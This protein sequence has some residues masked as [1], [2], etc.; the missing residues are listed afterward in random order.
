M[1]AGLGEPG[2]DSGEPE[3][4]AHERAPQGPPV[5]GE[6]VGFAVRIGVAEGAYRLSGAFRPEFQGKDVAGFVLD[7]RR[8]AAL[9]R[10]A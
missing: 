5:R 6:V 1:K 9:R 3:G 2:A 10:G 4:I 7:G 8:C